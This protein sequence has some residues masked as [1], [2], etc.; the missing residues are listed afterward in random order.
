M[1]NIDQYL[2]ALQS[3]S[4]LLAAAAREAGPDAALPPCP[5]W[6]MRDLVLHIGE[7]QRWCGALVRHAL[8]NPAEQTEEYLG[9]L[10][11][12]DDLVSW[13]EDGARALTATLRSADPELRCFTFLED[14]PAPRLFWARRQAH[15]VAMHRVDAESALGR[16]TGFTADMAADG[17]DELLTGFAPRKRTQLRSDVPRRLLIAPDDTAATWLVTISD[18]PAVTKRLAVRSAA[19]ADCTVGGASSD[20]YEALW[21]R[22]GTERLG[23]AGDA[24][25][26]AL[27]R[28]GVQIR[29]S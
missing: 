3:D 10:P 4:A 14:A 24:A 16:D 18:Q 1:L 7:V 13:F 2:A 6:V 11:G 5:E 22:Q 26:L 28:D 25:V 27:F 17:I 23:I 21:N 15:E 9:A 29:W 19:D 20:I 8:M 12:D